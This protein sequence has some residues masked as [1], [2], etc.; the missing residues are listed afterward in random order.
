M[1]KSLATIHPVFFLIVATTLEVSGDAVVRIAL[2]DHDGATAIRVGLFLGAPRCC[3]DTA[4]SLIS[5]R[6]NSGRS[7][8]FI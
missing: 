4:R 3:S 7:S 2:Y 1:F 8:V 5:H 6:S